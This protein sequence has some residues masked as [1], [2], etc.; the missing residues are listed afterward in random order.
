MRY[1]Q[2][3]KAQQAGETHRAARKQRR[4]QNGEKTC[5]PQMQAEALRALLAELQ[6]VQVGGLYEREKQAR[7]KI[8]RRAADR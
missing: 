8:P 5:A 6:D 1:K 2:T 3:N 4:S 7:E